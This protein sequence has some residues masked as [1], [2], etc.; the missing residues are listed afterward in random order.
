MQNSKH[1]SIDT[2]EMN[3]LSRAQFLQLFSLNLLSIL[4][5]DK[6]ALSTKT[7]VVEKKSLTETISEGLSKILT[8]KEGN[9]DVSYKKD[10]NSKSATGMKHAE[11]L[12]EDEEETAEALI[13]KL[14]SRQQSEPK[15]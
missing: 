11:P 14:R 9:Q 6:T 4:G 12:S 3:T 2:Y 8:R 13:E 5:L 7:T 1:S 10:G 15:R